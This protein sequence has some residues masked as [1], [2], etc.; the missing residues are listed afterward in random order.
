MAASPKPP[1]TVG[2]AYGS[3]PTT[4]PVRA[5]RAWLAAAGLVAGPLFVGSRRK[6]ACAPRGDRMVAHV[7]KRRCRAVGIDPSGVAISG[8]ACRDRGAAATRERD[9]RGAE[10]RK[11]RRP[12]RHDDRRLLRSRVRRRSPLEQL[13]LEVFLWGSTST[14]VRDHGDLHCPGYP[15]ERNLI[16]PACHFSRRRGRFFSS[17]SGDAA[18]EVRPPP[19]TVGHNRPCRSP[20]IPPVVIPRWQGF[21][22]MEAVHIPVSRRSCIFHRREAPLPDCSLSSR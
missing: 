20:A 11:V 18:V 16:I 12:D 6:A 9:G 14:I 5:L 19:I 21:H 1:G 2:V 22:K 4:C 3:E 15:R 7:V 13:I 10:G 8:A 17:C